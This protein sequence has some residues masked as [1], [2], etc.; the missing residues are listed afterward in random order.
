MRL[1]PQRRVV[2]EILHDGLGIDPER[3]QLL[4]STIGGYQCY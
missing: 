4:R 1:D 2:I 3:F